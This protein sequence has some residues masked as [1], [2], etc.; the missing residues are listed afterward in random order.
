[1]RVVC[2]Q[3]NFFPWAGYFE[4]VASA[5]V[6]IYLDTVQWIR[7]GRQHRTRLP[8]PPGQVRDEH[9][10]LT[11]PVLGHGHR[12]KPFHE[13]EIDPSQ[14]WRAHQWET[15]KSLYGKAPYFR[16]QLEP[17]VRPFYEK[18]FRFLIEACTASVAACCEPLGLTAPELLASDLPETGPKSTRLIGLCQ[19]FTADEYYSALGATRYLDL[20]EFRAA[21]IRVRWQHF[22]ALRSDDIHRPAD[23]S[24]LDWLAHLPL[25]EIRA[26]VRPKNLSLSDEWNSAD[27]ASLPHTATDGNAQ[28][29]NAP[30]LPSPPT[31]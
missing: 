9:F 8:T 19:E 5:D 14:N 18:E 13:I 7:Q 29:G 24:I 10:W 6:F 26:A 15:L 30:R 20:N 22:R 27:G 12:T 21:G 31:Q 25:E 3:P 11:V 17:V 28:S 2:Q 16:T 23:L 1:M 4:Q